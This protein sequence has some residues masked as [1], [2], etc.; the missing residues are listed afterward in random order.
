MYMLRLPMATFNVFPTQIVARIILC[1]SVPLFVPKLLLLYFPCL[2]FHWLFIVGHGLESAVEWF[3]AHGYPSKEGNSYCFY[4]V[5]EP[6]AWGH[7]FLQRPRIREWQN[8]I[9]CTGYRKPG[10]HLGSWLFSFFSHPDHHFKVEHV[11]ILRIFA[12]TGW[13]ERQTMFLDSHLAWVYVE[14]RLA[15]TMLSWWRSYPQSRA[16]SIDE[17]YSSQPGL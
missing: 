13:W 17:S 10:E 3:T 11:M 4:V 16:L 12:V 9:S 7:R 15:C 1:I 8:A 2:F 5:H 14:N 6:S